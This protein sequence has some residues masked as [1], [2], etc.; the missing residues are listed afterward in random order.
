MESTLYAQE[1]SLRDKAPAESS[2]D[3]YR[4]CSPCAAR[5]LGGYSLLV[6]AE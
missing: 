6:L 3:A 1:G 5:V 2:P 4:L